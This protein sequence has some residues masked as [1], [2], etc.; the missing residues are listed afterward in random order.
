MK[1]IKKFKVGSG[2]FF[3]DI[4]EYKSKDVDYVVIMDEFFDDKLS[5]SVKIGTDDIF[6][7]REL[8]KEE[9]I[10]DTLDKSVPMRA[11]KFLCPEFAGYLGLTIEDLKRLDHMFND[12]D[13]KHK[14]I[15]LIYRYY[16]ENN[17]FILTDEQRF[18]AYEL[19]KIARKS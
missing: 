10:R 9:F 3:S 12:M 14:Y 17:A 8:T 7:F 6:M 18:A 4:P 11:G 19:Y 1:A 15:T 2:C 16:I 13:E 5:M